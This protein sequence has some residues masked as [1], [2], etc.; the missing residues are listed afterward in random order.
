MSRQ[1]MMEAAGAALI[2][3]AATGIALLSVQPPLPLAAA[4]RLFRAALF[5]LQRRRDLRP[6]AV[7]QGGS[8]GD[9]L[10]RLHDLGARARGRA[11]GRSALRS[12]EE[13]RGTHLGTARHRAGGEG[14]DSAAARH[15]RPGWTLPPLRRRER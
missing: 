3:L 15:V 8:V 10:A 14:A 1:R 6:R 11:H 5:G 2:L 13:P 4:E 9:D 7:R 12:A